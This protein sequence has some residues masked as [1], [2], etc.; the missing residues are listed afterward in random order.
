MNINVHL[1]PTK[2]HDISEN[3]K[4]QNKPELNARARG[5]LEVDLPKIESGIGSQRAC[6]EGFLGTC[7]DWLKKLDPSVN[8][9]TLRDG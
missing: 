3:N 5:G 2:S 9:K 4:T 8:R 6:P 1:E 7:I